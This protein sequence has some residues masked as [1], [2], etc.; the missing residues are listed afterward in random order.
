MFLEERYE[1][2]LNLLSKNGK[3]LVKDLSQEFNISESMIRKDL[4]VLEK[5]NLLQRTY[6]GAISV[7][8][9]PVDVESFNTRVIKNIDLKN[10]IAQKAF[11]QIQKNDTV[12]LDAS[13][14]SYMIAKLIVENDKEITLIT[15]MYK[16]S[17]LIS[18][19]SKVK[20]IFIGGDYHPIVGGSIGSH[21]IT[22]IENYHCNKAFIGCS[23]VNLKTGFV[24][25]SLSEDAATKK[26]I[27]SISDELFL[28]MLNEK[29]ETSSTFNFSNLEDFNC[30]ITETTPQNMILDLIKNYYVNII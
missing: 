21:A 25:T 17:S 2:I 24:S 1:H 26:I 7:V 18:M 9:R 8:K 19:E 23:G 29:F 11:E 6:G 27:M 5:K 12:F 28:I 10:I 20:L 14:T 16:I 22:Q 15:N 4:K 3:V 13:S 30:I